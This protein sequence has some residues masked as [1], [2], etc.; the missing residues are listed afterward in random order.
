MPQNLQ[1]WQAK[2]ACIPEYRLNDSFEVAETS[3]LIYIYI[4]L[5]KI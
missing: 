3:V 5:H 2:L 1:V 4:Y